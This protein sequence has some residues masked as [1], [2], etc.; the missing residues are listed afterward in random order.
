MHNPIPIR[1]ELSES[2]LDY[3]DRALLKYM[4]W[5]GTIRSSIEGDGFSE[6]AEHL[7][8]AL[9]EIED[10]WSMLALEKSSSM[11]ARSALGVHSRAQ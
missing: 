11:I 10:A 1:R 7:A 2:R 3:Y 8:K 4:K 9:V 5:I 6:V